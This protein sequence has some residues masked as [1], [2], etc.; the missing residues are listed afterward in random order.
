MGV[1]QTSRRSFQPLAEKGYDGRRLYTV[2]G[3]LFCLPLENLLGKDLKWSHI[4]METLERIIYIL[5]EIKIKN[6]RLYLLIQ[7]Q[8][9]GWEVV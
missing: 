2:G 9:A 8:P 3:N 5:L 4:V 7:R 6:A 1:G